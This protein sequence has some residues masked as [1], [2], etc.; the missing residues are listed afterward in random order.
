MLRCKNYT[1][2]LLLLAFAPFLEQTVILNKKALLSIPARSAD[3]R[4]VGDSDIWVQFNGIVLSQLDKN[5]LYNGRWLND[6]HINYAQSLLKIQFPHIDGWREMLLIHK[7]QERIKQGLQI[8]YTH[9]NH[10]IVAFTI[11]SSTSHILVFYF[12][13]LSVDKDTESIILDLFE[14]TSKPRLAMS[15]I[16][17]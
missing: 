15:E 14:S 1:K 4:K 6:Q 16:S 3:M 10:W 5:Q 9:G 13:Y 8:I 17:K 2:R 11:E 12:L 7:N